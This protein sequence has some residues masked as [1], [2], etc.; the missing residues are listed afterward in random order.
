MKSGILYFVVAIAL[1]ITTSV[2]ASVGNLAVIH[3][4]AAPFMDN[5]KKFG[6]TVLIFAL[7]MLS[8]IFGNQKKSNK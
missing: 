5:V 6:P 4:Y 1:L 8:V 7:Y 2:Q 3:E